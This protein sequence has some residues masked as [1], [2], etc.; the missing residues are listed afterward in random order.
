MAAI[1]DYDT[2]RDAIL[3]WSGRNDLDL[4]LDDFIAFTEAEFYSPSVAGLKPLR[5]RELETSDITTAISAS[6]RYL[7][8]PTG[9]RNAVLCPTNFSQ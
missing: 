4:Y 1:T 8:L 2:L 6:S 3:S 9:F 7:A 5:V